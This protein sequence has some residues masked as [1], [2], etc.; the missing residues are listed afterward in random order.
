[1]LCA[2]NDISITYI[3]KK[4]TLGSFRKLKPYVGGIEEGLENSIIVV[5]WTEQRPNIGF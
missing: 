4:K 3:Y 1:V 5:Y 2:F